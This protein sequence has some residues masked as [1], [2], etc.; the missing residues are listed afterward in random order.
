MQSCC[1][2]IPIHP[3]HFDY[4]YNII[5]NYTIPFDCIFCFTTEEDLDN[6]EYKHKLNNKFKYI[7]F[8]NLYPSTKFRELTLKNSWINAKKL[9]GLKYIYQTFEYE[10]IIICDAEIKFLNNV[11]FQQ[12]LL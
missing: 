9:L 1:I 4:I 5:D 2:Y 8:S 12:E 11:F 7:I 3:K 10:Y 6:F